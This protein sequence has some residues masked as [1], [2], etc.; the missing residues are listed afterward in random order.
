MKRASLILSL[1]V[2]AAGARIAAA[3]PVMTT[4]HGPLST[5]LDSSIAAG[6]LISGQ[7]GLELAG[8]QGWHPANTGAADRLPAFTDDAG[9]LGSGLTGLLNDFPPAGAPT[10]RVQYTLSGPT[11]IAKIQILSGNNGRDGRVF[12]TSAISASTNGGG[13]FTP[14]G[15][16]QSD[17]SGT[18]NANQQ[19]GSTLVEIVGGGAP[20]VTG[21]TNLIFDFYAVSNTQ[22]EMRDPFDGVNPLTGVDDGLA[23]AF[24]SPLIFEID[25]LA[26]PE[27]AAC[28]LFLGG[29]ALF[30][31]C[32]ASRR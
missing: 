10:K 26:V 23:A 19:W 32:R 21:A 28:G 25:V 22:G 15:Y 1:A 29:L 4:S 9:I 17:L 11:D 3:V 13:S 12:S 18:V 8:D 30:S 14:I 16:F 6:D 5:S 31:V 27:P 7:I 2:V 24:E 20:L